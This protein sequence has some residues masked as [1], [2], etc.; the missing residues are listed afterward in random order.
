MKEI[1]TS[2]GMLASIGRSKL[3][4]ENEN[5]ALL[6]NQREA[7]NEL[8]RKIAESGTG[9]SASEAGPDLIDAMVLRYLRNREIFMRTFP[10]GIENIEAGPFVLWAAI[11]I[12][13][14]DE[15]AAA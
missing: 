8:V 13:P 10:S 3:R 7:V 4:S 5:M 9:A 2:K 14:H 1:L 12:S 11:M 15:P 6:E